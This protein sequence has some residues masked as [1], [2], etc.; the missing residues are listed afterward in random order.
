MT[1]PDFVHA[2]NE[3][4]GTLIREKYSLKGPDRWWWS[5]EDVY[6][7]S[8]YPAVDWLTMLMDNPFPEF[9]EWCRHRYSG[10]EAGKALLVDPESVSE[11]AL[12]SFKSRLQ[13]ESG[14]VRWIEV[15]PPKRRR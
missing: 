11:S 9:S 6:A 4:R 8:P 12:K 3:G 13:F 15:A 7:E 2:M 1:W 5:S 10:A 14:V